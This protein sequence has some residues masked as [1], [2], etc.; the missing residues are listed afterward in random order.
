MDRAVVVRGR[1]TQPNV[2]ELDEAVDDLDLGACVEVV[3]RLAP[4]SPADDST[5]SILAVVHRRELPQPL[6]VGLKT[7]DFEVVQDV[8]GRLRDSTPEGQSESPVVVVRRVRA[9]TA[10]IPVGPPVPEPAD[11]ERARR[12]RRRQR[13]R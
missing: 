5:E 13:R 8:A 4:Q 1:L 12:T 2:V 10:T 11:T 9:G 3:L 6:G 7:G